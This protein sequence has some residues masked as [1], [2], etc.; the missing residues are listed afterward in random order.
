MAGLRVADAVW[1]TPKTLGAPAICWR[2]PRAIVVRLAPPY[3]VVL[4][5]G[6][7]HTVHGDNVRRTEPAG[8][9][10]GGSRP[11]PS[12]SRAGHDQPPLL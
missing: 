7:E 4:V 6:R 5:D 12:S 8:A 1:L 3:V 9:R 11:R 10:G 2:G